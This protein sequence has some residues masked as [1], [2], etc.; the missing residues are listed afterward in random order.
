MG[1]TVWTSSV[2]TASAML[3]LQFCVFEAIAVTNKLRAEITELCDL[4]SC[5]SPEN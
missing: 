3:R 4:Q 5:M 1:L 2:D